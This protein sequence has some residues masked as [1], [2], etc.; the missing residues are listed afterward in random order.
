MKENHQRTIL[1]VELPEGAVFVKRIRANTPRAW[2]RE[3]LR[4]PKARLEFENALALRERGLPAVE[5]LAWGTADSHWPGESFLVTRALTKDPARRP[6][7]SEVVQELLTAS[8]PRTRAPALPAGWKDLAERGHP[9]P[10]RPEPDRPRHGRPGWAF[11]A[12]R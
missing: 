12:R 8:A 11:S 6:T 9:A 7:A 3:I 5:P 10:G 4:P 1:R 2:W